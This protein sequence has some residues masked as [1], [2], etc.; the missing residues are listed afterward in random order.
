M[1]RK[2]VLGLVVV[3]AALYFWNAS[4]RVAMPAGEMQLIA[5]R[6][7]H[8]TFDREGLQNDT[9]TAERIAPR[10]CGRSDSARGGLPVTS[11]NTRSPCAIA[12]SSPRS[13][14]S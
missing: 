9:C 5:H 13:S 10:A 7:V 1:L 3:V 2:I 14:R 11:S 8:Q 4:W 12:C 6:G